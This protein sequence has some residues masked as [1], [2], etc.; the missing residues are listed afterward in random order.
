MLSLFDQFL[1]WGK[2]HIWSTEPGARYYSFTGSDDWSLL[3]TR[4]LES[5]AGLTSL[6]RDV[7]RG[8]PL[9]YSMEPRVRLCTHAHRIAWEHPLPRSLEHNTRR[10]LYTRYVIQFR[11]SFDDTATNI[12]SLCWS[13]PRFLPK[14]WPTVQLFLAT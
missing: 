3:H 6:A 5:L 4:Y 11:E 1:S 12:V 2:P 8:K 10:N 13:R 9:P 14:P 7:S